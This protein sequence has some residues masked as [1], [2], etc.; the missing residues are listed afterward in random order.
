[1]AS[2]LVTKL[3]LLVLILMFTV[4]PNLTDPVDV[5]ASKV[6]TVRALGPLVPVH[7]PFKYLHSVWF[8]FQLM[9]YLIL[10]LRP[11]KFLHSFL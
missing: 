3:S 6:G 8:R 10:S 11:F 2:G 5:L 1:M 4:F 9:N 7:Q